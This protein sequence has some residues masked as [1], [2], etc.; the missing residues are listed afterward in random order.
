MI[1]F[2]NL[3]DNS[4]YFNQ[5]FSILLVLDFITGNQY[6]TQSHNLNIFNVNDYFELFINQYF[7]SQIQYRDQVFRLYN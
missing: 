7:H 1:E 4:K 2:H 3:K 6:Q 5:R